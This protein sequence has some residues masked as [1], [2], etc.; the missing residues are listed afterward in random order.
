MSHSIH[1]IKHGGSIH[2]V[3]RK[4]VPLET[5]AGHFRTWKSG[6]KWIYGAAVLSLTA[7]TVA[8]IGNLAFLPKVEIANAATTSTATLTPGQG[9]T[10]GLPLSTPDV[11]SATPYNATNLTT[12]A[13]DTF[14][15]TTGSSKVSNWNSGTLTLQYGGVLKAGATS[16]NTWSTFSSPLN[17][18]LPVSF[19][20]SLK[21]APNS[22]LNSNISV[23]QYLGAYFVPT[24]TSF[25]S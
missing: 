25:S 18:T 15:T 4:K 1:D 9:T 14:Y 3:K 5:K 21:A 24:G 23:G 16:G 20:G 11:T 13:N 2:D 10:T 7:G 22:A 19:S 17:M 8:P 6:K 12:A